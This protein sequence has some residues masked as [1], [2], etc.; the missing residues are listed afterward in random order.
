MREDL[1]TEVILVIDNVSQMIASEVRVQEFMSEVRALGFV[2][3]ICSALWVMG[4]GRF[5]IF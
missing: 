4:S 5:I 3:Q 1:K 2:F